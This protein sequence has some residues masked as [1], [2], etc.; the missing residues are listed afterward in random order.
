MPA[1]PQSSAP[2]IAE[3]ASRPNPPNISSPTAPNRKIENSSRIPGAATGSS[4]PE[5]NDVA[6][7]DKSYT[8][9]LPAQPQIAEPKD[10]AKTATTSQEE[11]GERGPANS[12]PPGDADDGDGARATARMLARLKE[13]Q[14]ASP[15]T[16]IPGD[17]LPQASERAIPPSDGR[18]PE[19][20]T[21][22]D[23]CPL[24]SPAGDNDVFGGNGR[25]AVSLTEITLADWD[26]CVADRACQPYELP[27]A[28]T[29]RETIV[30]VGP[31]EA[32]AY[33]AW[34]SSTSGKSYRLIM[35]PRRREATAQRCNNARRNNSG[36]EWL[37]DNADPAC[38][39]AASDDRPDAPRGFKVFRK[40]VP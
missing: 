12:S 32:E 33:R 16:A 19:A 28:G 36:W 8:Q 5:K 20:F 34:L 35:S 14:D 1:S 15:G 11:Q 2:A 38:P 4:R 9:A 40:I 22:C 26:R 24:V 37:E 7:A 25:V 27:P 21:D 18:S 39:P 13:P 31:H 10:T 29:R 30:E 6:G 23:E 17:V 3:N